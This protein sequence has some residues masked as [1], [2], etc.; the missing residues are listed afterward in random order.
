MCQPSV[1]KKPALGKKLI[2]WFNCSSVISVVRSCVRA[3]AEPQGIALSLFIVFNQQTECIYHKAFVGQPFKVCFLISTGFPHAVLIKL[4]FGI[5]CV[6]VK[7][8][9]G[10]S[11]LVQ[12][13]YLIC[14][15]CI[16]YVYYAFL[17]FYLVSFYCFCVC[18]VK[19][20]I[21]Q[22]FS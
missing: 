3:C 13:Q 9:I 22:D 16:L 8:N 7:S 2:H 21:L 15:R 11:I 19:F 12:H 6:N 18:I 1:M 20:L 5:T 4:V 14:S 17:F 10:L